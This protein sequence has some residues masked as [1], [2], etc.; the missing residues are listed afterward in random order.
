MNS[1][2][3]TWNVSGAPPFQVRRAQ[4]ISANLTR[5]A[6]PEGYTPHPIYTSTKKD[7]WETPIEMNA[8]PYAQTI[9]NARWPEESSYTNAFWLRDAMR[10]DYQKV[11]NLTDE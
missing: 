2:K 1:S 7:Y 3:T 5:F 6:A 10:Y 4:N 9:A 11:F 8:C